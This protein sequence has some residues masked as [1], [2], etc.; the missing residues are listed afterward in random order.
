MPETVHVDLGSRSYDITVGHGILSGIG[1]AYTGLGLGR[2]ALLVTNPTVAE[3]YLEPVKS[4]LEDAGVE[5]TVATIPDGEVHKTYDTAGQLFGSLI[6][7]GLD[8]RSCVVTLGG[9]VVGDTAGFVAA[10]YMRGIDFIQ[11]PTTLEAQ[12]DASVG[13]KT[14]V[15][16][17]LGKNVIGAFHQPRLVTIDTDTLR[18]LPPREV[19]AGMAEV[20]KH[21]FIRDPELVGL[22]EDSLEEIVALRAAPDLLDDLVARNCR[23]KVA[24]VEADETEKGVREILNYGHTVGHAIEA[25]TGYE[26]YRHGEAVSLGMLAAGEIARRKGRL[27]DADAE[28]HNALIARLGV[29]PGADALDPE[30]ILTR[31]ASDKKARDGVIRFVLLHRLG[32]ARSHDDVTREEI[33]AGI[34][35]MQQLSS[36]A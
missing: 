2:K 24:V 34:A 5:V 10:M 35:F 27:S 7:A 20:V 18:T 36:G 22:L 26:T 14:G 31:M 3:H 13:G 29:P 32:D 17:P 6:T 4:S 15:D 1:A 9:G 33:M 11:V 8:R 16:H 30:D 21:G 28:R 12:V 19:S 25:V 23:I